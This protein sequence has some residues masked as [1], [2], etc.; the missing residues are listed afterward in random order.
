VYLWHMTAGVVVLAL[1]DQFGFI[2]SDAPATAGWWLAKIPFVLASISV[3]ALIVPRLALV[4]RQALLTR[5]V[6]WTDAS[7]RSPAFLIAV[8]V[9]VSTAL[10]GW[11]S[12]NMAVIIPS[13]ATVLATTAWIEAATRQAGARWSMPRMR[14]RPQR[15]VQPGGRLAP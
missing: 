12:G 8:A 2:G 10:K 9:V 3:L 5:R 13:L 15:S 6:A 14:L 1:F 7:R 4:E 11:T